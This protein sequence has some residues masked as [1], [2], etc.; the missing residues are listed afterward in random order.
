MSPISFHGKR[1]T[2][3]ISGGAV[4][5]LK[6][7]QSINSWALYGA[8]LF[9]ACKRVF[10][11]SFLRPAVPP[12]VPSILE[13]VGPDRRK[14]YTLYNEMAH[15]EFVEWWLQTDYGTRSKINWDSNHLSDIWRH[16]DQ[17]A[18]NVDGAPKVM[19]KRCGQILEHP[20]SKNKDRKGRDTGHGL[21]TM[22]RHLKTASCLRSD[23]RRKGEIFFLTDD[24]GKK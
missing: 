24:W 1:D 6:S 12:T 11:A 4:R 10:D 3:H 20:Y 23:S 7:S 2:C 13:R 22:T 16:F 14:A 17:V 19:C 15:N 9:L 18:H 21:S 5:C 8:N